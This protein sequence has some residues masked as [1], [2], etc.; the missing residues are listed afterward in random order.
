MGLG[1][2]V[3]QQACRDALLW[4]E[5]VRVAVNVSAVQVRA[6]LEEAVRAA[7]ASTGLPA[8]RLKLEVTESV[9]IRDA[10]GAL[11]CLHRLRD[12]GIGTALDDFGTGSCSLSDLRRF[13][14][15]ELKIDGSFVREIAD[16]DRRR[17]C[18]RS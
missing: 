14:L 18:G 3:L 2:W 13:P 8:R 9:M 5:H 6:G 15:D 11:T 4:P 17:S 10:D 7:L 1:A 16:P 12:Q